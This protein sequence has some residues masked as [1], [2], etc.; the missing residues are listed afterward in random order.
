M[1][2]V[3]GER[4]LRTLDPR[5]PLALET[6]QGA[7]QSS[8]RGHWEVFLPWE[9]MDGQGAEAVVLCMEGTEAFVVL[10]VAWQV[11]GG[12]RSRCGWKG[13]SRWDA[14][15]SGTQVTDGT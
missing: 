4:G 11:R 14:G 5:C 10:M 6:L 1:R 15:L 7:Q 3:R 2:D 8:F 13:G 12:R 9:S